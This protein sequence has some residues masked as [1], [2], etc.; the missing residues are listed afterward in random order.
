MYCDVISLARHKVK[1]YPCRAERAVR[2][3]ATQAPHLWLV[4]FHAIFKPFVDDRHASH[5]VIIRHTVQFLIGVSDINIIQRVLDILIHAS[6]YPESA[7]QSIYHVA[8][9]VGA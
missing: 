4:Q 2:E 5:I 7:A 3:Y 6:F 9:K 8:D 1:V